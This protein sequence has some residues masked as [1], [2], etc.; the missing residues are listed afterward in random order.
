MVVIE[1]KDGTI[2]V[3]TGTVEGPLSGFGHLLR[4]VRDGGDFKILSIGVWVY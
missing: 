4:I 1:K 2:M 3:R